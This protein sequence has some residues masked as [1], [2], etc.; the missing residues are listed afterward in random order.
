MLMFSSFELGLLARVVPRLFPFCHVWCFDGKISDIRISSVQRPAQIVSC[1]APSRW[2]P[3]ENSPGEEGR[4]E[5]L[6][7]S[8]LPTES[9]R[10]DGFPPRIPT[11][12][13][14]CSL[15][16]EIFRC[17]YRPVAS[18][19]PIKPHQRRSNAVNEAAPVARL[20]VRRLLPCYLLT[21]G[22]PSLETLQRRSNDGVAAT[23]FACSTFPRSC[24]VQAQA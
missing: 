7:S 24:P 15:L 18:L 21:A 9:G 16:A 3:C 1:N 17:F 5:L 19:I 4:I 22:P 12:T 14:T 6:D 11:T 20:L 23:L 2:L 8:I 13:A 10:R